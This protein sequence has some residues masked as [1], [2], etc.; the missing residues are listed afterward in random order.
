MYFAFGILG[1]QL[2]FGLTFD[3]QV[4]GTY[5]KRCSKKTKLTDPLFSLQFIQNTRFLFIAK[6]CI[7]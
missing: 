7:F 6:F 5:F 4:K 1:G 2:H 3:P